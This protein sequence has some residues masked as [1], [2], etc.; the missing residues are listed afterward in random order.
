MGRHVIGALVGSACTEGW[1]FVEKLLLAVQREEGLRQAILE[2]I[3]EGHPDAF[4][5]FYALCWSTIGPVFGHGSRRGCLVRISLGRHVGQKGQGD[6]GACPAISRK[7]GVGGPGDCCAKALPAPA[8]TKTKGKRLAEP[9]EAVEPAYIALVQGIPGCADGN[10]IGHRSA[11]GGTSGS[12]VCSHA[13]SEPAWVDWPSCP[14]HRQD[15]VRPGRA[16]GGHAP[17]HIFRAGVTTGKPPKARICRNFSSKS[18]SSSN[19]P[20][21]SVKLVPLSGRG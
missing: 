14:G 12:P 7:S 3:D 1:E 10:Y 15:A 20:E 21:K 18:K 16:C 11:G 8:T 2:S 5:R 13:P 4:T 9:N 6:R 19:E 17:W